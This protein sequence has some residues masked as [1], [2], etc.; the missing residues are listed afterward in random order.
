MG[1][2]L[3]AVAASRLCA[4]RTGMRIAHRTSAVGEIIEVVAGRVVPVGPKVFPLLRIVDYPDFSPTISPG[5]VIGMDTVLDVVD[6][7]R[8]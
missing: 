2:S 5:D 6:R 1:R 4:M 3:A 7:I 8:L